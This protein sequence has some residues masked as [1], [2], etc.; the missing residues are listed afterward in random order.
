MGRSAKYI[1]THPMGTEPRVS[2]NDFIRAKG[3]DARL[4][5]SG[6][7]SLDDTSKTSRSALMILSRI[8]GES[9]MTV[10]HTSSGLPRP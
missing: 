5:E 10:R 7:M 1:R 9:S 2:M 4:D 8:M 3:S 6:S